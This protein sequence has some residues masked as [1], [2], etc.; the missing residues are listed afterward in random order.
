MIRPEFRPDTPRERD[1]LPDPEPLRAGRE[2]KING[3]EVQEFEFKG[4]FYVYVNGFPCRE[5]YDEA[6]QIIAKHK[7]A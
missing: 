6:I 1:C 4:N 5:S 2:I 3:H 7:G